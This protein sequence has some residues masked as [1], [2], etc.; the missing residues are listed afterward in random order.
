MP[1]LNLSHD[2]IAILANPLFQAL[3]ASG[4][5]SFDE[6]SGLILIEQHPLTSMEYLAELCIQL[7]ELQTYIDQSERPQELIENIT[8]LS[9]L[10]FIYYKQFFTYEILNLNEVLALNPEQMKSLDR[11]EAF[12]RDSLD[13]GPTYISGALEREEA[14]AIRLYNMLEDRIISKEDMFNFP[15]IIHSSPALCSLV[16][17]GIIPFADVQLFSVKQKVHLSGYNAHDLI[18][19]GIVTIKQIYRLSEDQ[20][21]RLEMLNMREIKV[22]DA[23]N[24]NLRI[25]V[26]EEATQYLKNLCAPSTSSSFMFFNQTMM[27]MERK[28]VSQEVWAKIKAPVVARMWDKLQFAFLSPSDPDFI[29]RADAG[30]NIKLE[31]SPE[32]QGLLA[33]SEG[34]REYCSHTLFSSRLFRKQS[35]AE[36]PSTDAELCCQ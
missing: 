25:V 17:N 3:I 35:W 9:I 34:Y 7:Q 13:V 30:Q 19:A 28:H 10:S 16:V 4:E 8:F 12:V 18:L 5:A 26:Q 27:D 29:E 15:D 32:I 22:D 1:D 14:I 36:E 21:C 31:S 23:F 33:N 11:L 6:E 20:L 24:K 2:T